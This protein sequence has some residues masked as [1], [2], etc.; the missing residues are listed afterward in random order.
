VTEPWPADGPGVVELPSG[1]RVRGGRLSTTTSAGPAPTYAV[2]LAGRPPPEP[3]WER[4][5][6]QW[7]DFWVP[8]DYAEATATLRRA[9][10]RGFTDRVEVA[11]GGG[12]GRT[13]TALAALAVLESMSPE[14][15]V[16]WVRAHYHPRA[17]EV[18]WQ[19][20]YLRWV[21]ESTRR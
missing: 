6:V 19:R 15:A 13:G 16:A 4:E 11:C 18:P 2:H 8:A 21:L 12:I 9:H 17:V 5:W 14:E 1:R 7:R 20:R 10:E 3:R